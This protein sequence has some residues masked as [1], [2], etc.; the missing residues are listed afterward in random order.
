[1]KAAG[2]V[3]VQTGSE[4]GVGDTMH[5]HSQVSCQGGPTSAPPELE[6]FQQQADFLSSLLSFFLLFSLSSK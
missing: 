4:I 3:Q 6:E 2:E 5:S 1:M